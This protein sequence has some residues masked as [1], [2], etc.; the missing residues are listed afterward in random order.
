MT[1]RTSGN[2]EHLMCKHCLSQLLAATCKTINSRVA[3]DLTA[4]FSEMCEKELQERKN[5]R[6]NLKKN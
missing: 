6:K 5:Q 1:K 2:I 3:R 4:K